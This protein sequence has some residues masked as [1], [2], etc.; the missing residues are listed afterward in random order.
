MQ[1][2]KLKVEQ[3]SHI[4]FTMTQFGHVWSRRKSTR[5]VSVTV[6]HHHPNR[7]QRATIDHHRPS[8]LR[9][10]TSGCLEFEVFGI[11]TGRS[12]TQLRSKNGS[13]THGVHPLDGG[14]IHAAFNQW[15]SPRSPRPISVISTS[16]FLQFQ[17]FFRRIRSSNGVR[18]P[19]CTRYPEDVHQRG[20]LP[21]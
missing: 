4:F 3:A 1:L 6:N 12:N 18:C 14:P 13:G 10:H 11:I 16:S 7:T 15:L 21:T 2:F 8:G 17:T 20:L 19:R 5:H 9:Y